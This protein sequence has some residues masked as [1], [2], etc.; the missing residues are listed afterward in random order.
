[1][2]P[3]TCDKRSV[4]TLLD[5]CFTGTVGT[6]ASIII[7]PARRGKSL[8]TGVYNKVSM[9]G[10]SVAGKVWGLVCVVPCLWAFPKPS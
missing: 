2:L 7:L 3:N 4:D 9:I 10:A 1:M 5:K 8:A 6:G